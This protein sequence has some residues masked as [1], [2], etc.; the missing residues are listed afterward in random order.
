MSDSDGARQSIEAL[1]P[2][3]PVLA[4]KLYRLTLDPTPAVPLLPCLD[5]EAMLHESVAAARR[6]LHPG[7][8]IRRSP[9]AGVHPREQADRGRYRLD[10][11]RELTGVAST[12][13]GPC[14]GERFRDHSRARE[15]AVV[16]A[17]RTPCGARVPGPGVAARRPAWPRHGDREGADRSPADDR[18]ADGEAIARRV[19]GRQNHHRNSPG[20][21]GIRAFR[22]SS[23]F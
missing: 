18:V 3:G 23:D 5:H 1:H 7:C 16:V 13:A 9:R 22:G 17:R 19:V 10:V 12:S 14:C 2:F 20:G 6:R 11:G 15:G 8:L 4:I 21:S